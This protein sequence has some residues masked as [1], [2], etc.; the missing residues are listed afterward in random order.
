MEI[1]RHS[2]DMH[3]E[4]RG[5]DQRGRNAAPTRLAAPTS[6]ATRDAARLRSMMVN[7]GGRTAANMAHAADESS[8]GDV[9]IEPAAS[10]S[11]TEGRHRPTTLRMPRT[12]G[13]SLRSLMADPSRSDARGRMPEASPAANVPAEAETASNAGVSVSETITAVRAETIESAAENAPTLD[14]AT[15]QTFAAPAQSSG[16]ARRHDRDEARIATTQSSYE[17]RSMPTADPVRP[18]SE[19]SAYVRPATSRLRRAGRPVMATVAVLAGTAI[20]VGLYAGGGDLISDIFSRHEEMMTTDPNPS[21]VTERPTPAEQPAVAAQ[22]SDSVVVIDVEHP[23]AGSQMTTGQAATSVA[24]GRPAPGSQVAPPAASVS[25]ATGRGMPAVPSAAPRHAGGTMSSVAGSPNEGD[26]NTAN[27]GAHAESATKP[28]QPSGSS[29]TEE[30]GRASRSAQPDRISGGA[31]PA[32]SAAAGRTAGAGSNGTAASGSSQAGSGT[33]A[34]RTAARPASGISTQTSRKG[35][36]KFVVQ[37][38]A[39][40]DQAEAN[41]VAKRLKSKGAKGV[42]LVRTPQKDGT[43]L[44]RIRYSATGTAASAQEAATR[45][46]YKKVWVVPKKQ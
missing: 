10:S 2:D 23:T 38:R 30:T 32:R 11:P 18:A 16:G 21:A 37:V 27:D 4:P 34:A 28:V 20:G 22:M 26:R 3:D 14:P 13:R 46:G 33:T 43:V 29:N 17:H 12:Q 36:G 5:T 24:G 40:P 39:T 42:E 9:P 44:Y 25:H 31:G 35:T 41:L 6:A 7:A 19:R 1:N 45:A 15:A 8:N